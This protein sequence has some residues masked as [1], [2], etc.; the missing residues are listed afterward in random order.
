MKYKEFIKTHLDD[1]DFLEN[2]DKILKFTDETQFRKIEDYLQ[3]VMMPD[4]RKEILD[5][6]VEID[7]LSEKVDVWDSATADYLPFP[8]TIGYVINPKARRFL[9]KTTFVKEGEKLK[10]KLAEELRKNKMLNTSNIWKNIVGIIVSIVGIVFMIWQA[11]D[12]ADT[13]KKLQ[14]NGEAIDSN[15]MEIE[16]LNRKIEDMSNDT[17][18]SD[19]NR[20]S[21][22]KENGK[23]TLIY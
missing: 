18:D 4:E 1:S 9:G 10:S 2:C 14:Q 8:V 23:D 19:G 6:M 22:A 21:D 11:F 16:T 3:L 17:I 13:R 15:V 7:F 12:T 20:N 5:H